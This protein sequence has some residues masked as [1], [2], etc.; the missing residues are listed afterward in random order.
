MGLCFPPETC[1]C[2]TN[3]KKLITTFTF[4]FSV[5]HFNFTQLLFWILALL[6]LSF[7]LLLSNWSAYFCSSF[8]QNSLWVFQ[9][10]HSLFT[11]VRPTFSSL[12]LFTG[13]LYFCAPAAYITAFPSLSSNQYKSR[14]CLFI[15]NLCARATC[16]HTLC[17]YNIFSNQPPS[18]FFGSLYIFLQLSLSLS[19]QLC[20]YSKVF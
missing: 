12:C 13:S 9:F 15:I 5:T 1:Q 17:P 19:L 8:L 4:T 18:Y 3:N 6:D 10:L 2:I 16:L 14:Q 20:K 11:S 7:L